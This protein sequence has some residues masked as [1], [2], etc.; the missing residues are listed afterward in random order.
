MEQKCQLMQA[1][2]FVTPPGTP[3]VTPDRPNFEKYPIASPNLPPSLMYRE[4]SQ[5]KPPLGSGNDDDD[6]DDDNDDDDD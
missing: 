6:D 2:T 4:L 3:T 5:S 1:L